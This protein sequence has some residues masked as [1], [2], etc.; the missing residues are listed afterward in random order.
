[1]TSGSRGT[2]GL[3]RAGLVFLVLCVV[4]FGLTFVV[5][6]DIEFLVASLFFI[7]FFLGLVL[8]LVDA[9]RTRKQRAMKKAPATTLLPPPASPPPH[10]Q[11]TPIASTSPQPR[12][13]RSVPLLNN[14]YE[15]E[16][17]LKLGGMAVVVLARDTRTGLRCAIKTP[18][19]D[20]QHDSNFNVD[21]LTVEA[22]YL[23]QF[24]HY[25]VVRYI[26]L[27]TYANTVHLVVDYVEGE[28]LLTA[29]ARVPA[30]E[31]RVIK[32]GAQIL[33]A[34][35]YIHRSGVVHRDLNPANVMLR[36][37]DDDI[38]IIDFGT[39]KPAAVDGA[40]VVSKPGF[41]VPEQVA[42][43]YADERSDLCG[44]G[45]V[46]FYLLTCRPPAAV[47]N[48]DI[49]KLLIDKGISERTGQCIAQALQMDA[50]LRFQSAAAMRNALSG[51]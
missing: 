7:S 46:L 35:E 36:W 38:V 20:T 9:S 10:R 18:R 26:D 39:L 19:Y 24:S 25:H 22:A 15:I 41:E 11:Q 31:R 49:A 42:R 45:G 51:A 27:F 8:I 30:E 43:G 32:W 47:G 34:L 12:P 21:K 44:V 37:D 33:S 28:D 2:S 16:R 23:R 17:P 6:R 1:M 4:W 29:F 48:R 3:K 13:T 40:T 50:K 14:R 5:D